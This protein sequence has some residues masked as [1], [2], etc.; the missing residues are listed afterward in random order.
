MRLIQVFRALAAYSLLFLLSMPLSAQYDIWGNVENVQGE[1]MIGASIFILEADVATTSDFEGYYSLD[2]V[3]AGTHLLKVTYIGYQDVIKEIVLTQDTNVNIVMPG[4]VYELETIELTQ[5]IFDKSSPFSYSEQGTEEIG[6][7]NLAQD[8]PLL[9]EH[10]PSMVVTT[11]A[12]AGVGYSGMRIR[13]S[14][15][16]RVN[17]NINGIPLNDSE[18]HG[19]FWVNLPDLA[20]SV[21]RI[22]IQ[23]GVGPSTNGSG[24]FGATVGLNT[25]YIHQNPFVR[26]E[27]SYGSFNTYKTAVTVSTGLMNNKYLIEGRY[28]GINS[29]GYMDRASSDLSSFFLSAAK[30]DKNSSLRLNVFGGK[31]RTFQAWNGVPKVKLDQLE[32]KATTEDLLEHY[33]NNSNGQYNTLAD[34]LNLFDSGR[35]YNAYLYENEVDDYSQTHF[36]LIYNKQPSST[37]TY[38]A[39][40]HFTKGK[41]FFEQYKHQEDLADFDPALRTVSDIVVQRW[42]DN[43]FFGGILNGEYQA[44]P[45]LK[46]HVGTAYNVYLGDHYGDVVN[47]VDSTLSSIFTYYESDATKLDANAFLKAEYQLTEKFNIYADAQVRNVAYRSAGTD[48]DGYIFDIDENFTFFN[49]K[50]G[51]SMGLADNQTL[52][53]SY[54][55]AHREPVRGDFLDSR[56]G[57]VPRAE[58]LDDYELGYRKASEKIDWEANFYYMKY[59]DQLVLT[60]AVN[61]VGGAVRSNVPDSY[62]AGVELSAKANLGK[63]LNW[64]PNITLSQNRIPEYSEV[65]A[66]GKADGT[67]EINTTILKDQEISFSPSVVAGSIISYSPLHNLNISALSKY[68][69]K[70]YLDNTTDEDRSLPAYFVQ[71][72][73]ASYLIQSDLIQEV[74][75]K[76]VVNNL[77]NKKYSSNGYTY[78]YIYE[79]LDGNG[80]V[81]TV[82]VRENYLFPQ[83]GINFLFGVSVTF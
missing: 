51:L 1:K 69:G 9:V 44:S 7:K 49:P 60:G 13:G 15:A 63:Y 36:Q 66:V 47:V 19:V 67:L 52:Y 12:G 6:V 24:A 33:Y 73:A 46:L 50:L 80:E 3:P 29:D 40:A 23:R 37:F 26:I 57:L 78:G 10:T 43:E 45:E 41:G 34:S 5:P 8:L 18:S 68:V 21:E 55:R 27:G 58:R 54:A 38:N 74:E 83:A 39:K 59:K 16:T 56:D 17:V 72:L 30:V 65:S 64:S 77:F 14:D 79:Y 75:F 53:A 81:V 25:D 4:S 62:R 20:T 31:E 48:N 70:Q 11:D 71:D 42:L 32:G 22:Q 28:S 61:D 82:S 76:L 35:T 2:S